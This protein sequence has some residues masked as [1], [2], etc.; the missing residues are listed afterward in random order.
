M[1]YRFFLGKGAAATALLQEVRAKICDRN[2]ARLA[3]CQEYGAKEVFV[4]NNRVVGLVFATIREENYLKCVLVLNCG[5]AHTP[6]RNTRQG[7]LLSQRLQDDPHIHFDGGTYII[8]RLGI[9]RTVFA[10]DYKV[11]E[12]GAGFFNDTVLVQIPLGQKKSGDD[13]FPNVP[14]WLQEVSKSTFLAAQ[15]E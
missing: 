4:V 1:Q 11:C 10:K 8:E 7:K 9:G 3:L 6:R 5:Y 13:P 15:G 14:D 2:L 12:T